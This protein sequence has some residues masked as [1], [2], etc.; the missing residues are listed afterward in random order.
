MALEQFTTFYINESLYG[1]NVRFVREINRNTDVTPVEMAPDYIRGLLNLRGQIVTVLDCGVRIGLPKK[2]IGATSRCIVLKT[3]DDLAKISDSNAGELQTSHDVIGLLIDKI[4]D[5]VTVSD[6]VIEP[7]PANSGGIDGKF[8]E[9][10][11]KLERELLVLLKLDEIL[12]TE[13]A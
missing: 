5:M 3:G 9:G 8:F 6:D 7:P 11:I 10:V 4:G 13:N 1:I 12:Q 2:N